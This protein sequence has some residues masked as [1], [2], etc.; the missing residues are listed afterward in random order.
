VPRGEA[1]PTLPT[2][3]RATLGRRPRWPQRQ[4]HSVWRRPAASPSWS[5]SRPPDGLGSDPGRRS[6]ARARR[7][8]R[9]GRAPG[10]VRHRLHAQH[11][12]H[13]VRGVNYETTLERTCSPPDCP[14]S[15]LTR[16]C[17]AAARQAPQP[18]RG[19]LRVIRL[20]GHADM[21]GSDHGDRLTRRHGV[22]RAALESDLVE[23]ALPIRRLLVGRWGVTCQATRHVDGLLNGH[24]LVYSMDAMDRWNSKEYSHHR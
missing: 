22:V 5:V 10:G 21:S 15:L 3:T 7:L 14:P 18:T 23:Q 2:T 4:A 8:Y 6:A 16:P 20:T 13:H 17:S 19:R 12:L 11:R 1:R 9:R 24:R